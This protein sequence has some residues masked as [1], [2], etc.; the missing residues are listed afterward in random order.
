MMFKR[1]LSQPT[2]G[3]GICFTVLLAASLASA[4]CQGEDIERAT[5]LQTRRELSQVFDLINKAEYSSAAQIQ[6]GIVA[7]NRLVH[8]E[9]DPATAGSISNLANIYSSMGRYSKAEELFERALAIDLAYFGEG[10]S[11]LVGILNSLG[12]LYLAI[13]A[14]EKAEVALDRAAAI[15]VNPHVLNNQGVLYRWTGRYPLSR[16][17]YQSA[18]NIYRATD[19]ASVDTAAELA[20]LASLYTTMGDKMSA[21]PLYLEALSIMERKKGPEHPLVAGVL[22][23]LA[24]L[25]SDN[26]EFSKAEPLY[27][28]ALTIFDSGDSRTSLGQALVEL[29][30][31]KLY[32]QT[33]RLQMA[34]FVGKQA[35]NLLQGLRQEL[36]SSSLALQG[37]FLKQYEA[38]YQL[39]AGWLVDDGRLSEAQDVTRMLKEQELYELARRE[40][41]WDPRTTVA[42]LTELEQREKVRGDAL[43]SQRVPLSRELQ[44]LRQKLAQGGLTA[45]EQVRLD[46]LQTKFK[47]EQAEFDRF[48]AQVQDAFAELSEEHRRQVRAMNLD[49][50]QPLQADLG[51]LGHGVVLVTYILLPKELKIILTTP[52]EQRGFS[53]KV[54]QQELRRAVNDLR[55]AIQRRDPEVQ[56]AA[57]VLNRWLLEPIESDLKLLHAQTLMLS[58]DDVLRYVPFS[59]LHDGNRWLIERYALANYDEASR[60]RLAAIRSSA[61]RMRAFGVSRPYENF[62]ALIAVPTELKAITGP[63]GVPSVQGQPPLL[64]EKFTRHSL[65]QAIAQRPAVLHI[66]SHFQFKG[67]S[68]VDSFLLLGDGSHL[69]LDD[70]RSR[71]LYGFERMELLTLSACDTA[72]GGGAR[73][74]GRE[75]EGFGAL[76]QNN[77]AKAVLASLWEVGD[78]STALLM[79]TFYAMRREPRL[80]KAQMLQRAQ[81]KLMGTRVASRRKGVLSPSADAAYERAPTQP[82]AHPYY[83]APF[84]LMGNWL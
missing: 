45:A 23:G 26:Q 65:Q 1:L 34:I 48:L 64:N 31:A 11:H 69:T 35:V 40:R 70:F 8:G 5:D 46:E 42:T 82:Y 59:A 66:A 74:D 19:P 38:A 3:R 60:A 44:E 68:E 4:S 84:V 24:Q 54:T 57:Q 50:L 27:L 28:R 83:W 22:D 43:R 81:L 55:Q 63:N 73:E 62:P 77:G 51:E 78:Q 12:G 17:R 6:E 76:A 41:G 30:L 47:E 79:Q 56:A 37:S 29:H 36:A 67:G 39:V 10:D 21:E 7:R 72:M 49:K 71:G 80:T 53:V 18:L 58:L 32:S 16:N 25:Y 52:L 75:V 33:D 9:V 14:Y 61:W 13:G 2:P 20:N 15:D